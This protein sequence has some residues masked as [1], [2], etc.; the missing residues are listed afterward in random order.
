MVGWHIVH[1]FTQGVIWK[2]HEWTG[3]V[4]KFG[5]LCFTRS[6]SAITKRKQKDIVNHNPVTILLK[7]FLS[8][9]KNVDDQS[10]TD[11]P[12]TVDFEVVLRAI[13][14]HS[15]NNKGVRHRAVQFGSSL[16]PTRQK[17]LKLSNCAHTSKILQNLSI[18]LAYIIIMMS[19]G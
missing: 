13:E 12:N 14:C 7:K 5:N 4:I 8:V 1:C 18:T 16:L 2:P 3:H 17:H 9:C 6:N 15:E 19:C 10:K 11:K